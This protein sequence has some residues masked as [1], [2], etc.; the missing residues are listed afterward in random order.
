M[1]NERRRTLLALALAGGLS[2]FAIGGCGSTSVPNVHPGNGAGGGGGGGQVGPA[3][4]Q[5]LALLPEAQRGSTYVGNDT[6]ASCH[7]SADERHFAPAMNV[8]DFRA[9]AHGQAQI[10]CEMCHGPGSNHA[11]GPA[12]DNILGFP[13][14]AS[15]EVCAA[16]HTE[17]AQ[18]YSESKHA[19]I[20]EAPVEDAV[21]DPAGRRDCLTCH[22]APFRLATV[23]QPL[24]E[25]KDLTEINAQLAALSPE[26]ISHM[27]EQ[28]KS[29]VSCANCHD[30]HKRTG[31]V[32]AQG[33]D[34]QVR[35][36]LTQ[37]NP[38]NVPPLGTAL[39]DFKTYDHECAAC[40][41]GGSSRTANTTDAALRSGSARPNMHD[42]PQFYM[43]MGR[44][45]VESNEAS[46]DD[47]DADLAQH[48]VV[49]GQC[50]KCH[51]PNG[52]HRMEVDY[53]VSCAPCHSAS[54]AAALATNQ[55]AE[56]TQ[57]LANLRA[58]FET[59]AQNNHNDSASW[60]YTSMIPAGHVR[61]PAASLPIELIRARHNYYFI[62]RDLS[63]GVHNPGY[64]DELLDV[65]EAQMTAL[66]IAPVASGRSRADIEQ[67]LRDDRR[68]AAEAETIEL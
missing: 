18:Q 47:T 29:S 59:W 43:L 56:I 41:M 10:A 63:L 66:G 20:V 28:T 13:E 61:P 58:R 44:G 37:R 27:A 45:G 1:G 23:D 65:A 22:S 54:D 7:G 38:A 35:R 30:P 48:S 14:L 21:G 40:H 68:R 11:T 3:P 32:N 19:H 53:G 5:V 57:R 8:A 46:D 16:C 25:G 15:H 39:A 26:E 36:A 64:T 31:N 17:V 67:M 12:E 60:D 2:A 4:D 55:H 52:N 62:E 33:E 6:C 50:S 34:H 42:N 24:S 9:S 51:M 49:P